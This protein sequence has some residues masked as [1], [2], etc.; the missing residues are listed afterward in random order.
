MDIS[1]VKKFHGEIDLDEFEEIYTPY[2]GLNTP[3]V[4]FRESG[5]VA[6]NDK[7]MECL[8][9]REV[10]LL[11]SKDKRTVILD[12]NGAATYQFP[13]NGRKKD[14]SLC[15]SVAETGIPL[16]ARYE[17]AFDEAHNRWVASYHGPSSA[18]SLEKQLAKALNKKGR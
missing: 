7:L 2:A 8:G 5:H 10:R 15:Q 17:A 4:S 13:Q 12:P 14:A 6:L 11:I 1:R 3:A 16:P 9:T 18:P